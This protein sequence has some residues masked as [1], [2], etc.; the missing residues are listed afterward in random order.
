MGVVLRYKIAWS[1]PIVD[2]KYFLH[3]HSHFAFA[4]WVSQ[5]LMALLIAYI[6]EKNA[7]INLKKYRLLLYPGLQKDL[8]YWDC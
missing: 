5:A 7:K 8:Q 3:A 1:L 4:G 6:S 2:Q